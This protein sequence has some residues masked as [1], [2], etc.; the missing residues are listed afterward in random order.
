M[1][2]FVRIILHKLCII[3]HTSEIIYHAS[4]I[5]V[6]RQYVPQSLKY[7]IQI[8]NTNYEQLSER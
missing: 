4:R 6:G 7:R 1:E 3:H 2:D 5:T 8:I